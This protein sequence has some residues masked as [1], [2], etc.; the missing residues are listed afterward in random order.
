MGVVAIRQTRSDVLVLVRV[1]EE[2]RPT[3]IMAEE[4]VFSMINK[5]KTKFRPN[6]VVDG[7][8]SSLITVKLANEDNCSKYEPPK[9]VLESAKK[10][11]MEY[12][13]A[14]SKK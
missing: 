9:E 10:A 6:L 3:G 4:R 7:T 11:T 1:Y 13:R 8:L 2:P 14:H 5:N 12:N